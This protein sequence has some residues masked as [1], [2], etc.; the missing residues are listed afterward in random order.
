MS[1]SPWAYNR[2]FGVDYRILDIL[3][4]ADELKAPC[5]VLVIETIS[6]L[7]FTLNVVNEIG[8]VHTKVEQDGTHGEDVRRPQDNQ[9]L[10]LRKRRKK[11]K[12]QGL[13]AKV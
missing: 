9:G 2:L 3:R 4:G 12:M 10:N 1:R 8:Y 11:N 6:E 7:T 5:L 13:K